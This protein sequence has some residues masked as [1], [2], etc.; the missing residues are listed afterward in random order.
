[1]IALVV[2]WLRRPELRERDRGGWMEQARQS[3]FATHTGTAEP[4]SA[5]AAAADGRNAT[6]VADRIDFDD[7]DANRERYNRWLASIANRDR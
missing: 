3:T 5:R 1:M 6:D 2:T 7:E 4:E